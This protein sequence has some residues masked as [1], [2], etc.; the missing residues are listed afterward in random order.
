MQPKQ[1]YGRANVMSE[2][3]NTVGGERFLITNRASFK[4]QGQELNV[5]HRRT[6]EGS[7]RKGELTLEIT[8]RGVIIRFLPRSMLHRNGGGYLRKH[9]DKYLFDRI[10]K[11]TLHAIHAICTIYGQEGNQY[12]RV[13]AFYIH[14][15]LY[16]RCENET[17]SGKSTHLFTHM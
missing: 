6:L 13:T 16:T 9:V 4:K 10:I 2:Y 11:S 12:L 3:K 1:Q 7:F 17:R 5:T 15:L 8:R 14:R